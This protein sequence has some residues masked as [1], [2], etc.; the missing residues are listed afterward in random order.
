MTSTEIKPGRTAVDDY[1][2]IRSTVG[3]YQINRPLVRLSGDDRYEFIDQFA[4]RSSEYVDPETVREVIALSED[5]T[6]F[7]MLLHIEID[8]V[9]WL[10]PRTEVTAEQL[11]DY[12]GQFTADDVTVEVAPD[13]FAATAFEGPQAWQ[14]AA[15]FIDFDVSGLVLHGVTTATVEDAETAFIARV[16]TTGEY[17][18]VLVSDAPGAAYEAAL[19]AASS[20]GGSAIGPDGLARVQAEAG[21]AIYQLDL[22]TLSV[23]DADLAWMIDWNRVGEFHGSAQLE[24]PTVESARLVA[25]V[26]PAGTTVEPG[27]VLTAGG[28]EVG[29][30]VKQ[31]SSANPAEELVIAL[32]QAP[33]WVPGVPLTGPDG[34]AFTTVTMPRVIAESM[35]VKID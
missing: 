20:V 18:Y 21:Q 13:G 16:G 7:A 24:P 34:Q 2:T 12:L 6:P 9:T 17:G 30:V 27:A 32:V 15:K 35:H 26:A 4:S 19:S 31:V 28:I 8:D 25:M 5:G 11:T 22:S 14:V 3:V 1:T 10:L 29:D 33:L 23:N